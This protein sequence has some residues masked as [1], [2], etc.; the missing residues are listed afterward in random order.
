MFDNGQNILKIRLAIERATIINS[1]CK[2]QVFTII[3]N[4]VIR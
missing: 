4:K 2:F 3:C 1:L